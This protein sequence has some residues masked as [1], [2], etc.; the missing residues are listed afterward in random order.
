V[1]LGDSFDDDAAQP[2]SVPPRTSTFS[3]AN[4]QERNQL[5]SSVKLVM[6]DQALSICASVL[7][8]TI[9]P[10]VSPGLVNLLEVIFILGRE[11]VYPARVEIAPGNFQK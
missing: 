6:A 4:R 2:C 9:G 5:R 7:P 3:R 8:R 1:W 11:R 10:L